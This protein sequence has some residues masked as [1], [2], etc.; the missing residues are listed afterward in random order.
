MFSP[1]R[2]NLYGQEGVFVE[3]NRH[4]GVFP[5]IFTPKRGTV[6][7]HAAKFIVDVHMF[8]RYAPFWRKNREVYPFL[9]KPLIIITI[10][11][12]LIIISYYYNCK[13]YNNL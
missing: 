9:T 6:R 5:C 13:N 3:L 11:I 1:K 10:I 8:F 2:G 7:K 4:R 12:I